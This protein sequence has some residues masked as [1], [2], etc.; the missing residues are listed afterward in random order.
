MTLLLF[1][2]PV[3]LLGQTGTPVEQLYRVELIVFAHEPGA[4][5]ASEDFLAPPDPDPERILTQIDLAFTQRPDWLAIPRDRAAESEEMPSIQPIELPKYRQLLDV[6]Q[7]ELRGLFQ[8]LQSRAGHRPLM[9]I[10]WLQSALPDAEPP[11]VD[12]GAAVLASPE[13]SGT[14]RLSRSRFLHLE[15]DLEFLPTDRPQARPMPV[16]R[17][18]ETAI[19]RLLPRYRL[20]ESRRMRSQETHY[21]D[22]PAFGVI[23]KVTPLAASAS[24]DDNAR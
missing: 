23:A 13:L 21:F 14:A 22:H 19:E 12:L 20:Q 16:L 18:G 10:M 9:H 3:I 7:G 11:L 15:L 2:W 1:A 6:S 24:Q 4:A 17:D 8:R 5:G